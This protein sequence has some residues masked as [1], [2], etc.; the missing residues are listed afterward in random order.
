[1]KK[2]EDTWNSGDAYEYFICSWSKMMA[3]VFLNWINYFDKFWI[4]K[5]NKLQ[6]ILKNK[7]KC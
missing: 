5:L 7:T 1:M 3:P 2:T 4:T 6:I